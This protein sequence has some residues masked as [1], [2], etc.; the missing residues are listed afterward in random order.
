MRGGAQPV[1]KEILTMIT[2]I[3]THQVQGAPAANLDAA[4]R[5]RWGVA[6]FGLAGLLFF[7]GYLIAG[8]F[9][10]ELMI[11][12]TFVATFTPWTFQAGMVV[13]MLAMIVSFFGFFGLYGY[14]AG[15][16][17]ERLGFAGLIL[18]T[19]GNGLLLA[20]MAVPMGLIPATAR[21]FAASPEQA[22]A[23][24]GA[25]FLSPVIMAPFMLVTFGKPL[26]I[27]LF[28]IGLWRDGRLPK[29]AIALFTIGFTLLNIAHLFGPS[30]VAFAVDLIG[31]TALAV[32]G[33]WLAQ[34]LFVIRNL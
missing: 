26:A 7:S 3:A 17:Q 29:A 12:A 2:K 21:M 18:A 23:V 13:N 15:A 4:A 34:S 28:A 32:G 30:T 1:K 10:G 22:V 6:C 14:L 19:V 16:G 31:G 27:V 20:T 25:V 8:P 5:I 11:P 24:L 33:F 9:A